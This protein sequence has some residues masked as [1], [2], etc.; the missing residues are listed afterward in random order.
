MKRI[1][2][3]AA[4]T[5]MIAAAGAAS[6]DDGQAVTLS[7]DVAAE[8]MLPSTWTYVS[9]VGGAN[10][11]RWSGS[12][13]T[14]GENALVGSNSVPVAGGEHAIRVRGTGFCNTSHTISV[15]SI[16]GGL[17]VDGD[18]NDPPPNG[19]GNRHAL[20]YQA[21]WRNAA[22]VGS[23][24]GAPF[25]PHIVMVADTPGETQNA[26]YTVSGALPPPGNRAFDIRIA[27][28]RS[29]GQPPLVAGSYSDQLVVTL[30]PT[31]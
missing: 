31:P 27:L 30:T 1:I 20:E 3:T 9:G 19:F 6:A 2:T 15:Q 11:S 14:I 13:F 22:A 25:G 29:S 12:V 8:C 18:P 26:N 21:S 23:S 17:T 16:R 4:M 5:A 28:A 24:M 10:A 7:G